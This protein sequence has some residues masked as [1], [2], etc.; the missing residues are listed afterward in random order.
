M[1]PIPTK[2]PSTLVT[3]LD[4]SRTF[5]IVLFVMGTIAL[6]I[7]V[8]NSTKKQ[9]HTELSAMMDHTGSAVTSL[10]GEAYSYLAQLQTAYQ[11][12]PTAIRPEIA[13]HRPA[14][15]SMPFENGSPAF[16]K[17]FGSLTIR[18]DKAY[19]STVMAVASHAVTMS[20]VHANNTHFLW[21]YFYDAKEQF[22]TVYPF[23]SQAELLKTTGTTDS[24][25]TVARIFDAGGTNPIPLV[26]PI[27]NPER[28]MVWTK[29][30][31]DIAGKGVIVSV[32]APVYNGNTF[33]GA[34]GTDYAL[35]MIDSLLQS[36]AD[37]RLSLQ[38]V[39]SE[40]WIVAGRDRTGPTDSVVYYSPKELSQEFVRQSGFCRRAIQ[41]SNSNWYLVGTIPQKSLWSAMLPLLV[42][43]STGSLATLVII[44]RLFR[45]LK[46]LV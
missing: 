18:S 17:M 40:G 30:Y 23:I 27:S 45:H 26:G 5:F 14:I 7:F 36:V 34:F 16:K 15:P 9:L 33:M 6:N 19:D 8:Y 4:Q 28:K 37:D 3:L 29:P 39:T 21:S 31:N 24:D 22:T 11:S 10:T 46:R 43:L 25:S 32:L 12:A 38:V 41:L 35:Q 13:A 2:T 20:A 1:S 44:L 42:I